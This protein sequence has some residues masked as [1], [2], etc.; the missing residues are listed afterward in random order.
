[1]AGE[2]ATVPKSAVL[3]RRRGLEVLGQADDFL[4]LLSA[5]PWLEQ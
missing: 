2:T 1:M 5:Y 3:Q 4:N